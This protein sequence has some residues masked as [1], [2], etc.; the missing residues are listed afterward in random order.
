MANWERAK[1]FTFSPGFKQV[2][3]FLEVDANHD[4]RGGKW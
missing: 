2:G 4:D 1:Q 3:E